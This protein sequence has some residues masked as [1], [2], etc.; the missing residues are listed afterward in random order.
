MNDASAHFDLVVIGS[1]PGGYTAAIRAAQLKMKVAIVERDKLGGICLNWGCIPTKALLKNAELF[2]LFQKSDEWGI[3][4]DNLR[5]DFSKIVKKSRNAANRLNKGVEFLMKKNS[6]ATYFGTAR[7]SGAGVV[8]ILGPDQQ[9]QDTL[10]AGRVLLATGARPRTLPGVDFDGQKVI[11]STEALVLPAPPKSMIIIGAGAIGVEFAYFYNT[12]GTDVT[13]VEMMPQ[14][15]PVEDKEIADL[16]AKSLRK[17]RIKIMTETKVSSLAKTDIGVEVT[18]ETLQGQKSQLSAELALMSIGVRGNH[19]GLG[20]EQLGVRLNKDFIQV[21]GDY[22]TNV[23]GIYAIGDVIGSPLLAHVA[24]AEG[25]SAVEGM[26][27]TEDRTK[28][29]YENIPGCTYCQPQVASLGLTEEKARQKGYSL[30]IGRFPFRANGKAIA[31]GETEG[32]VKLIF[33]AG[34]GELLGAHILGA[35]ATEMIAELAVAKNLEA[36]YQEILHTVHAHPTLTEAVMEAAG[37]AYGES[38]NQ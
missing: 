32:L 35:E 16:L 26:A 7:L 12:F 21:D 38:I 5:F 20:L 25:I 3:S 23:P 22:Q 31:I 11:W 37:D 14:I 33:D 30:K 6:I 13:L 10:E 1:G 19:E 36:T 27:G 18:V 9:L 4:V 28:V 29:I 17:S 15:L 24:S 8:Q 2:Q 34:Y